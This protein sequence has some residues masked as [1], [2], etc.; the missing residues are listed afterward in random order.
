MLILIRYIWMFFAS[1][2]VWMLLLPVLSSATAFFIFGYLL[3]NTI[4]GSQIDRLWMV[5]SGAFLTMLVCL[6]TTLPMSFIFWGVAVILRKRLL[7][8]TP[9]IQNSI[10]ISFTFVIFIFFLRSNEGWPF[11][12]WRFGL[13]FIV[14]G[15]ILLKGL[16]KVFAALMQKASGSAFNI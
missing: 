12:G 9:S 6:P 1:I 15:F 5:V 14:W 16:L 10:A 13:P 11:S 7:F 4:G 2:V 3:G 8:R